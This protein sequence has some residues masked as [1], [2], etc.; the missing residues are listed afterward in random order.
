LNKEKQPK[1][2]KEQN[3]NVLKENL[4][5]NTLTISGVFINNNLHEF[6]VTKNTLYVEKEI[7][8]D[9]FSNT[10]EKYGS[11]TLS[12]LYGFDVVREILNYKFNH[13]ENNH[14]RVVL[15]DAFNTKSLV[16]PE[17][18]EHLELYGCPNLEEISLPNSLE[19]LTILKCGK[20]NSINIP[21]NVHTL[22]LSKNKFKDN[23][24]IP[25]YLSKLTVDCNLVGEEIL[26]YLDNN[27]VD[28]TLVGDNH[29]LG[30]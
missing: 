9:A 7:T 21:E 25:T 16:I 5:N 20:L 13:S 27:A 17:G 4:I 12:I 15:F 19:E 23:F 24:N 29:T 2:Q 30:C 6:Y 14:T 26:Y 18:V 1:K 8:I 28:V 22:K 10:I 11:T 3:T